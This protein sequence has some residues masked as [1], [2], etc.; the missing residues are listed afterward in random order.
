MGEHSTLPAAS[1][2]LAVPD[3]TGRKVEVAIR[4]PH[5]GHPF[6]GSGSVGSASQALQER[7]ASESPGSESSELCSRW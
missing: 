7:A 2:W 6:R 4:I 5:S 3:G 1:D